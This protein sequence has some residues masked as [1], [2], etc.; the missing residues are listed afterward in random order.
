M[1]KRS[2]IA[3]SCTSLASAALG[4]VAPAGGAIDAIVVASGLNWPVFAA[5]PPGDTTRLMIVE[6]RGV[7]RLLFLQDRT[8]ATNPFL[9]I[10]SRVMDPTSDHD[11][12]GLLGMAFHPD[13]AMNGY[14]FVNYVDNSG[15]T[16][17]ARFHVSADPDVGDADSELVLKTIPQPQP[18]HNGGCLQFG[19]DGMLY[20]GM[21]DGGGANDQHETIGNGQDPGTLL[22]KMLRLDIDAGAP[23]VPVDNPY[24]GLGDPLDEIWSFGLRHP[25]RFSFDRHTGDLYIADVGQLSW[26]EIHYRAANSDTLGGENY[27]WRCMEGAH[28]SGLTGCACDDADLDLPLYE[29][30]HIDDRCAVIGGYVYR[31]IDMPDEVGNYFFADH[32]T[33]ELWSMRLDGGAVKVVDR[34]QEIGA[35]PLGELVSFGEDTQGELYVVLQGS[36]TTGQILKIVAACSNDPSECDDGQVCTN[37]ACEPQT[38][39]CTHTPIPGCCIDAADCLQDETCNPD[40]HVCVLAC[41]SDSGCDDSNPCTNDECVAGLCRSEF[42][43]DPCDDGNACTNQDTCV[44]GACGGTAIPNCPQTPGGGPGGGQGGVPEVPPPAPTPPTSGIASTDVDGAVTVRVLDGDGVLLAEMLIRDAE[45]DTAFVYAISDSAENNGRPGPDEGTFLGFADEMAFGR[46]LEV[47]VAAKA[48]AFSI[49]V[50]MT[51]AQSELDAVGVNVGEL[52][53]HVLDQAVEP[54]TWM[55]AGMPIGQAPPNFVVGE[56]GYFRNDSGR[57]ALWTVRDRLSIFAVGVPLPRDDAV[58]PAENVA[59]DSMPTEEGP[60]PIAMEESPGQPSISDDDGDG[61]ANDSD[62]CPSTAPRA[63]VDANGCAIEAPLGT[64]LPDTAEP[65]GVGLAPCGGLGLVNAFL[66]LATLQ[67]MRVRA[68]MRRRRRV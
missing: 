28:C 29:Y 1:T 40:S 67:F 3:M 34:T 45:P 61:V 5:G 4:P 55:P 17:I 47:T 33:G 49:V 38:G 42:N 25:W 62:A 12:R 24:K 2:I 13:Y 43:A 35:L 65:C 51:F 19:P 18:N 26:E 7:I 9:D 46:T 16:V 22:G 59:P 39:A 41:T 27:G 8:L 44:A 11:E 50:M 64:P 30:A 63:M 53:L 48:G 6:K 37:D 14:F 54:A 58:Q 56:S 21:G 31:G 20:V 66:V 68:T 60:P 23:Y 36:P 32:C 57:W 10:D 52:E 15:D